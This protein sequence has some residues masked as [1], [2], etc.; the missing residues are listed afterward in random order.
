MHV[1]SVCATPARGGAPLTELGA[2]YSEVSN[3]PKVS[4]LPVGQSQKLVSQVLKFRY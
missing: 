4:Q 1:Y 3:P 2:G